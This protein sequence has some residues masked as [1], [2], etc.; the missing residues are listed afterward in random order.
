VV[1]DALRV[2]SPRGNGRGKGLTDGVLPGQNCSWWRVLTE[3]DYPWTEGVRQSSVVSLSA[4]PHN[5]GRLP[6]LYVFVSEP[7]TTPSIL[8]TMIHIEQLLGNNKA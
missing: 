3:E 2:L 4:H 7:R 5:G 6:N 1:Q 8:S